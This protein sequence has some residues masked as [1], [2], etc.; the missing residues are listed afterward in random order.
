MALAVLF[1]K[2]EE[3]IFDAKAKDITFHMRPAR[4]EE[5]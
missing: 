1:E 2:T 5:H 3:E 4:H